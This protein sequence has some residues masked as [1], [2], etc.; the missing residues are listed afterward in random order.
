[1]TVKRKHK[2]AALIEDNFAQKQSQTVP[3]TGKGKELAQVA[4]KHQSRR[5]EN[6]LHSMLCDVKLENEPTL[7]GSALMDTSDLYVNSDFDAELDSLLSDQCNNTDIPLVS[8]LIFDKISTQESESVSNSSSSPQN[9]DTP[10]IS[11]IL[12]PFHSDYTD[13]ASFLNDSF[14][15]ELFPQ[16][17]AV[18]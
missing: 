16:L 11:D 8:P 3:I 7:D 5:T 4:G 15:A 18:I 10:L 12:D 9:I 2:S 6:K 17:A 13:T 14:S 1:M